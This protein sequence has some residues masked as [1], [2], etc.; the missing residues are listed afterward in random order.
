MGKTKFFLQAFIETCFGLGIIVGPTVG[1]ALFQVGGYITPFA[2]MGS[3]LF[4]S[5]IFTTLVL[6]KSIESGEIS[7]RR[8]KSSIDRTEN[9][10]TKFVTLSFHYYCTENSSRSVIGLQYY[11]DQ[12]IHWIPSGYSGTSPHAV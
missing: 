11:S 9:S 6:P 7:T 12:L 3:V 1:G 4:L 10:L 5:S 2:V 8:R